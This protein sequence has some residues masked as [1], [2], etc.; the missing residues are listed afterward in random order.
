M[1]APHYERLR[2]LHAALE[3]AGAEL[4]EPIDRIEVRGG[5]VLFWTASEHLAVSYN[6][7]NS[8]DERGSPMPGSGRWVVMPGKLHRSRAI[9]RPFRSVW[10]RLA[11]FVARR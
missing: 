8:Y 3:A 2:V 5:D 4:N 6:Y 10:L 1:M 7:A 9:T 11:D